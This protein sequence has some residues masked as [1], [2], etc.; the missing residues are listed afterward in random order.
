MSPAAAQ[1]IA[2]EALVWLLGDPEMLGRFLD[3]SGLDATELR[4]RARDPEF[5]GF[6][7][8]FLLSGDELLLAF[9]AET[10]HP[11]TRP[12]EARAALPGGQLP[13]WT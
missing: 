7:L 3:A 10:G 12:G 5:L 11:A 8:D 13:N 2:T 9:C 6:V 1:E 4:A